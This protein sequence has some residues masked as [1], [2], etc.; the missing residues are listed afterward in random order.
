MGGSYSEIQGNPLLKPAKEYD[1]TLGY[2]LKGKYIFRTWFNHTKDYS[3]QTLYQSPNRLVE[4][5]KYINFNYSQ[6]A[7]VQATLPFGIGSWLNSRLTLTGVWQHERADHFWDLPFNRAIFWGMANLNN[8][9]TLSTKPDLKLTL[10]GMIRST[11][12][13]GIYDLP[14]SGNV[15]IALRYAFLGGNAIVNLYANDL[16]E[17][18]GISPRIRYKTQHVDNRYGTFRELGVSFTWKFGGY[19]EKEREQVDTSRFK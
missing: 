8:T 13:Q 18:G 9:F 2:I 15:N 5:Y 17:T 12:H 19:K 4:I 11:A 6:Q 16:F 1:L 7:G 14:P 3:V 10:S